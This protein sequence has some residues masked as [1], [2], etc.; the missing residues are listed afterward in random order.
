NKLNILDIGS[1]DAY[2]VFELSRIFPNLRIHCI[3]IEYTP[4]IKTE[5]LKQIGDADISLY[6]SQEE[7]KRLNPDFS[8]DVILL[9]DVIEHIEDDKGFLKSL[10]SDKV[11]DTKTNVLITVPAHQSLFS[12][13]DIFLKHFRRYTV[14]S[15]LETLETC[16]LQSLKSGYFFFSLVSARYLQKKLNIGNDEKSQKG[17][18]SYKPVFLL[19]KLIY[20]TLLFDYYFFKAFRKWGISVSG[21][22]CYTLC[23]L[24]REL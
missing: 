22:S 23:R 9:L 17:I 13:H 16:N 12:A 19:D 10:I 1:G 15:L 20:G 6:D 4:E 2:M 24:K 3:D 14:S 7:Y 11:I 18:S 5:L 8:P 21:L